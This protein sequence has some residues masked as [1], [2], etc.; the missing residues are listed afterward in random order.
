VK[1][2]G[3]KSIRF[4][5]V[6]AISLLSIAI[7]AAYFIASMTLSKS[8]V[9]N[10]MEDSLTRITQRGAA[11]ISER[12]NNHYDKL[13]AIATN[14]L[15]WSTHIS[16]SRLYSLLGRAQEVEGYLDLVYVSSTGTAYASN[17]T[18]YPIGE[19]ENYR[20]GMT[21]NTFVTNPMPTGDGDKM[22][23]TYSVPVLNSAGAVVGVLMQ[24]S[25]GYE[26]CDLIADVTYE[27]T[28]YA[29]VVNG[30]GVMMAHP[31]RTMVATQDRTMEK[32]ASD[33]AQK[34]LADLMGR[35]ITGETG[36]G[37]YS[38]KNVNK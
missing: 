38:Y 7:C 15:F 21:G 5:M 28:G 24:A 30:E 22:V 4:E 11:L 19:N 34:G 8:A 31:D 25:D 9:T 27:K 18:T 3:F 36:V 6:L 37:G 32:A 10:T 12:V 29:F 33:P 17:G 16:E 1:R 14:D 26:L 2:K 13:S 23:M 20:L 35:M